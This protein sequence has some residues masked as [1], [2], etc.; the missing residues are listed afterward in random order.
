[1]DITRGQGNLFIQDDW[2]EDFYLLTCTGVGDVTVPSGDLTAKYCP[3]P[4]HSGDFMISSYIRGE[5]GMVSTTLTRPLSSVYNFLLENKCGGN[6]LITWICEGARELPSRYILAALLYNFSFSGDRVLGQPVAAETGDNDRVSVNANIQAAALR[7][8]YGLEWV[9]QTLRNT[10]DANGVVFL[11]EKCASDCSDERGL[12]EIGFLGL[13]GSQYNSEVKYTLDFGSN[14]TQ[15]T[16]DPFAYNGGDSGKPIVFELSGGT[17]RVIVPRISQAV[18]EYAEVAITED[19]GVTWANVYVGTVDSAYLRKLWKYR[20]KMWACGTGGYIYISTDLGDTWTAQESGVETTQTLNDG[21]MYDESIGYCVGNNNEFLYTLSGGADWASRVGPA[22]GANLL[23][24]AVNG[25]GHVYVGA[26]DATLYRTTDKGVTWETVRDFGVG[27]IPAV[28]FDNTLKYIGFLIYN[29]G[30]P[31]GKVYRSINGGA[32]WLEVT[33][34][35]ANAGLN[36]LWICDQNTAIVVGN[37]Y[38]GETFVAKAFPV[39]A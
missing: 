30:A 10:A 38:A 7:M 25:K 37:T 26:S 31:V 28:Y 39:G 33:G 27:T 23:S 32:T 16:V 8:I 11:P 6:A 36:D 34:L 9:Q 21:T 24:V 13:D 1:M 29:T 4:E 20:G 19:R 2:T 35:P 15:T 18:G 12:C 3:D 17:E 22:V 5:A 14:W